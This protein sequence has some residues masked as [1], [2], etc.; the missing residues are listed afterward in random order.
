MR[1]GASAT[2][3]MISP[4]P[5]LFLIVCFMPDIFPPH[6]NALLPQCGRAR[7][8]VGVFLLL[9]A[10]DTQ[11]CCRQAD[12]ESENRVHESRRR[13]HRLVLRGVIRGPAGLVERRTYLDINHG[14]LIEA[15]TTDCLR[16]QV[17]K[18][19]QKERGSRLLFLAA[20]RWIL[21]SNSSALLDHDIEIAP[22]SRC[23]HTGYGL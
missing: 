2:L 7:V 12:T 20:N 13:S 14:W 8:L 5:R 18:V 3:K 10:T 1:R 11:S 19:G 23:T 21:F 6:P 4:G 17:L 22:P 16:L 15:M 9:F